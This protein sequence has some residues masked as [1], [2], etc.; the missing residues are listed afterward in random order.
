MLDLELSRQSVL[1]NKKLEIELEAHLFE[2][3]NLNKQCSGRGK[4]EEVKVQTKLVSV[5]F[6]KVML[7]T[8]H[9]ISLCDVTLWSEIQNSRQ[10]RKD[11][12]LLK[13]S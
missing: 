8:L 13:P 10:T 9:I 2:K 3:L 12:S 6:L 5:A 4:E 7:S 11:N 1:I